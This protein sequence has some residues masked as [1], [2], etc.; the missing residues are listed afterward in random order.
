M[1][2]GR[3]SERLV[4]RTVT[5]STDAIGG[6]PET[7]A[8]DTTVW[9]QMIPVRADERFQA[10]AVG[11][12]ADYRFKVRRRTDV[13]AKLRLRWT[14]RWPPGASTLNLEIHG[15]QPDPDPAFMVLDCGVYS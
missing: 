1:T 6:K 14:P 9:A 8:T 4:I 2:G 3:L 15:V 10:Q 13:T 5:E 11:A 7:E 12:Q